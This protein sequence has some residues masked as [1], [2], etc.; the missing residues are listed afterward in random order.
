[1][2]TKC[3]WL[4]SYCEGMVAKRMIVWR[5]FSTLGSKLTRKSDGHVLDSY[6]PLYS[7]LVAQL[8]ERLTSVDTGISH[9]S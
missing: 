5:S 6:R 2:L 8:V 4:L 7:D 3:S 1:M 9:L